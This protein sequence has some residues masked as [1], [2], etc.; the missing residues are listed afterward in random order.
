MTWTLRSA[1]AVCVCLT[2]AL[3]SPQAGLAASGM[4]MPTPELSQGGF[5]SQSR[6]EAANPQSLGTAGSVGWQLPAQDLS[7]FG[8]DA[9]DQNIVVDSSGVVTAVWRLAQGSADVIQGSRLISG[10]WTTP[11]DLSDP[12]EHAFNAE[13]VIDRFGVVTVIWRA[14]LAG[15]GSPGEGY[16]ASRYE[17]GAWSPPQ[18]I[19]SPGID[20]AGADMVVDSYGAVT[21]VWARAPSGGIQAVRYENGSWGDPVDIAGPGGMGEPDAAIDPAGAVTVVWEAGDYS[22]GSSSFIYSA[23]MI[24][25]SWSAPIELARATNWPTASLFDSHVAVDD[26]GVA[27]AVWVREEQ[28]ESVIEASRFVGDAWTTPIKLSPSREWAYVPELVTDPQGTVTVLWEISGGEPSLPGLQS[29]RLLAGAW[30]VPTNLVERGR[31]ASGKSVAVDSAGAVT[32]VFSTFDGSNWLLE[33]VRLTEGSWSTP[34]TLSPPGVNAATP[35]IAVG[36]HDELFV[37]W[38]QSYYIG[39][40]LRLLRYV[41][42]PPPSIQVSCRVSAREAICRGTSTAIAVGTRLRVLL[43]S[44]GSK[45]WKEAGRQ[46]QAVVQAGGGFT[47]TVTLSKT[48]SYLLYVAHADVQ[49]NTVRVNRR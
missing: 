17:A 19:S 13:A 1:A 43:R 47:M 10:Q 48:G 21:V 40:V 44:P 15:L 49:S 37:M 16:R 31:R 11:V 45:V 8:P 7:I 12:A 5:N 32:V 4:S 35:R 39:G 30:S 26:Q 38:R 24:A 28:A 29:S 25:G 6:L 34:V 14:N 46:T 23:R 36:P 22:R 42:Y 3:L 27:T 20:A 18:V 9:V 33:S 2:I 41:S